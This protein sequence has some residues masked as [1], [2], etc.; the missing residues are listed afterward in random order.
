M[1]RLDRGDT[2]GAIKGLEIILKAEPGNID[3][4]T[5]L[6]DAYTRVG[7]TVAAGKE[8]GRL[9]RRAGSSTTVS[10]DTGSVTPSPPPRSIVPS[11]LPSFASITVASAVGW[12]N[13]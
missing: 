4:R 13:T 11:S 10:P 8:F 1:S 6:V 7:N 5:A 9:Q 2:Q 3:A 12:L